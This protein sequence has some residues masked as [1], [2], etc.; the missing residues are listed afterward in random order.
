MC[1]PLNRSISLFGF[2]CDIPPGLDSEL[3]SVNDEQREGNGNKCHD[4]GHDTESSHISP[5][6]DPFWQAIGETESNDISQ[7][8]DID[9]DSTRCEC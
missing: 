4:A 5:N 9:K 6:G 8:G 7:A 2:G 3:L 1:N